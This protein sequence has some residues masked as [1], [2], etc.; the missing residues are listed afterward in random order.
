VFDPDRTYAR[1]LASMGNGYFVFAAQVAE[2]DVDELTGKVELVRA[3]SVH[4]V[5]RAINPVAAEGQ[6]QGGFVQGLGYALFEEMVWSD[7]RLAN[8]SML[9]YKIPAAAEVP[10][11]VHPV[12]LEHPSEEGPFGAKGVAEVGLVGVAPAISNAIRHATGVSL[13]RIPA[14]S[15]RVLRALLE[16]G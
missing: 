3:W 5:G 6:I 13:R 15:E 4:D 12:M 9:D 16:Q 11:E 14:T 10:L 1:G 7:G 2:V 8:P